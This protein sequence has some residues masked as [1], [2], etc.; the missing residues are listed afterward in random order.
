M[1]IEEQHLSADE[2][3]VL[4]FLKNWPGA[5]IS[6]AEIT[7]RAD[8]KIRHRTEPRWTAPVLTQL[9]TVKLVETDGH[10]KYRLKTSDSGLTVKHGGRKR[11]IAPH[12][13]DILEKHGRKFD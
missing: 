5:F 12:L 7:R 8:G 6:A 2:S 1:K 11:F 9:V 10:G 3:S 4:Q 13:R